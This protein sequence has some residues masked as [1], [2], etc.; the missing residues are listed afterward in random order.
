MALWILFVVPLA[1]ILLALILR[2]ANLPGLAPGRR[3]RPRHV[4]VRIVCG[5]LGVG[6]L[7]TVAIG[8]VREVKRCYAPFESP[9][10]TAAVRL[11]TLS[12]PPVEA[13]FRGA[14]ET[15][16][17]MRFLATIVAVD[18]ATGSPMP[19]AAQQFEIQWP[20]DR[21]REYMV[22]LDAGDLSFEG[23]FS[24]GHLLAVREDRSPEPEVKPSG[25]F[26]RMLLRGS[27]ESRVGAGGWMGPVAR[28]QGGPFWPNTVRPFSIASGSAV[29]P[30]F[31]AIVQPVAEND[32]LGDATLDELVRERERE[33]REAFIPEC[34]SPNLLARSSLDMREPARSFGL[35]EH[36]G[37]SAA[38]LFIAAVF[39][40]QLFTRRDAAFALC[41]AAVVLYVAALDRAALGMHLAR[42]EDKSAAPVVRR[43]ACLQATETFFYG[44]TA[45]ARIEAVAKD[46]ASP[47]ELKGLAVEA[48]KRMKERWKVDM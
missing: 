22:S 9:S 8:T 3:P 33:I 21:G 46:E 4:A 20:K 29:K 7:V 32:P 11:P 45:L 41:L 48:A 47:K 28:I 37:F 39:L 15:M 36:I 23:A 27:V 1:L 24:M 14:K 25:G 34:D 12:P 31:F 19:L 16:Q 26:N 30:I 18:F 13:N 43:V 2:R 10:R 17:K 35:L 42:L 40:M 44:N 6:I 38:L 5:V